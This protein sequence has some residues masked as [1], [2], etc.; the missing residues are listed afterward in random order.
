MGGGTGALG[1]S[2]IVQDKASSNA[3]GFQTD[4]K[5]FRESLKCL[6][7]LDLQATLRENI[8]LAFT[9]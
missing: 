2:Y 9:F 1:R 7:Y 3:R 8:A 6:F 4:Y 5:A